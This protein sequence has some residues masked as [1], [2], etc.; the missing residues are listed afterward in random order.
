[1]VFTILLPLVNRAVRFTGISGT[2]V[3]DKRLFL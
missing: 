2:G 3:D 1:M